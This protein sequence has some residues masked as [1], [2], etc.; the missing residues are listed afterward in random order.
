MFSNFFDARVQQVQTSQPSRFSKC[1]SRIALDFRNQFITLETSLLPVYYEQNLCDILEQKDG[2]VCVCVIWHG[3]LEAS[4]NWSR[5]AAT[6]IAFC[7]LERQPKWP[8]CTWS[9]F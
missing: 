5:Q 4:Q 1:P 2:W 3:I 6:K 7:K 9:S 8:L